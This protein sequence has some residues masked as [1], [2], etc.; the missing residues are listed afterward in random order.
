MNVPLCFR[1]DAGRDSESSFDVEPVRS[2]SESEGAGL[3]LFSRL[4]D[5]EDDGRID[6]DASLLFRCCADGASL[7]MWTVSVAEERH[8]REEVALKD[9]L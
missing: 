8:R 9:M 3:R 1:S 5:E 4:L 7:N 2:G 6:D